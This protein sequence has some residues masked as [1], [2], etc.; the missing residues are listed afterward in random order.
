MPRPLRVL[1][2]PYGESA[3]VTTKVCV[4]AKMPSVCG[5]FLQIHPHAETN[6]LLVFPGPCPHGRKTSRFR[7]DMTTKQME[8]LFSVV[9]NLSIQ[10][11]EQRLE[12][13]LRKHGV[14]SLE[15]QIDTLNNSRFPIQSMLP[16]GLRKNWIRI[17]VSAYSA[18]LQIII[19]LPN[20]VNRGYRNDD[21]RKITSYLRRISSHQNRAYCGQR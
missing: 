5:S 4:N 10:H 16:K 18:Y 20:D 13:F 2:R 3:L 15:K 8:F 6:R 17:P 19:S 11:W 12:N 9:V 1:I 21:S 14:E 7:S